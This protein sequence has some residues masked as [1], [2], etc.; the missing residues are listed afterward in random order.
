VRSR[1][2]AFP[3]RTGSYVIALKLA[4]ERRAA[5][6]KHPASER[7]VAMRL[8]EYFQDRHPFH[9]RKCRC[10][11][12]SRTFRNGSLRRIPA[13][14]ANRWRQVAHVNCQAVTERNRSRDAV[15]QFA[16]ISW[17]FILQQA[18]H[19]CGCN[20]QV[21]SGS[22]AIQEMMHEHGYVRTALP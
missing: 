19:C 12:R 17:P 11:D 9:F 3:G 18:L 13:F 5:D 22:V 6:A 10:G 15:F 20:L 21:G 8:F 1:R 4:V 7:L 14:R 16:H 2:R